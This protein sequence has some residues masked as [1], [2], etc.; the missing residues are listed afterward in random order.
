M[1]RDSLRAMIVTRVLG[2]E[3]DP[4]LRA[5][6]LGALRGM[7]AEEVARNWGVAGSQE[8]ETVEFMLDGRPLTVEAETFVGLSVTGE[9]GAVEEIVARIAGRCLS[10]GQE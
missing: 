2:P 10:G 3:I 9:A 4:E 6:L 5:A 1:S 8:I 7:G